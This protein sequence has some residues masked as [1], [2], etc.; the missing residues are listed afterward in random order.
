MDIEEVRKTGERDKEGREMVIV[1]LRHENQKR[2]E[3]WKKRES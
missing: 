2:R 1:R 3:S